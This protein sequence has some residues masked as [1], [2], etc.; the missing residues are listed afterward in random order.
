MVS[1]GLDHTPLS[2]HMGSRGDALFAKTPAW[3][4]GVDGYAA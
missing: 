3:E 4:N 2:E 1:I